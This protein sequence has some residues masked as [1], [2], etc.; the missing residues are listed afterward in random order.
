MLTADERQLAE[1][2]LGHSTGI[3][4]Y[5]VSY[6]FSAC[7][8]ANSFPLQPRSLHGSYRCCRPRSSLLFLL[9]YSWS[10]QSTHAVTCLH[11]NSGSPATGKLAVPSHGEACSA[12][13]WGCLLCLAT[14]ML[15]VP[16]HREACCAQPRGCLLCPATGKLAVSSHGEACSAQLCLSAVK[17]VHHGLVLHLGLARFK[18]RPGWDSDCPQSPELSRDSFPTLS[19][20]S[21]PLIPYAKPLTSQLSSPCQK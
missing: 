21:F 16:S 2:H 10:A 5:H 20:F 13:P 3:C 4:L 7:L 1:S 19:P 11:L 15:A 6:S 17:V 12:Q 8:G 9:I 18:R 14:G